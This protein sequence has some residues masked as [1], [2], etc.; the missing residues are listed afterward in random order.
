MSTISQFSDVPVG[1]AA[2]I[3]GEYVIQEIRAKLLRTKPWMNQR[4]V[5]GGGHYEYT[6]TVINVGVIGEF[7]GLLERKPWRWWRGYILY[8]GALWW[9]FPCR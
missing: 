8:C 2:L 3:N 6:V 4:T 9:R 7:T 1:V 5:P